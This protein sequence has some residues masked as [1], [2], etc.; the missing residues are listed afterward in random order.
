MFGFN[1]QGDAIAADADVTANF[2]LLAM[3]QEACSPGGSIAPSCR[4]LRIPANG[5]AGTQ[6]HGLTMVPAFGTA[7][8]PCAITPAG[9][10]QKLP[11]W[12]FLLLTAS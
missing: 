6:A 11:A 8:D 5:C 7:G 4:R 2:D 1:H 3:A 9:L 12:D 10:S